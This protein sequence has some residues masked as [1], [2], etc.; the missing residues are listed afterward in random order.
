MPN[1]TDDALRTFLAEVEDADNSPVKTMIAYLSDD[2][3]EARARIA[4]LEG[5]IAPIKRFVGARKE[6]DAYLSYET[7]SHHWI[8]TIT[9]RP[10]V[11]EIVK[12][13]WGEL[14]VAAAT[15]EG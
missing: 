11:D 6:Q 13:T 5:V 3:F 10:E 14:E 8:K 2:I 12:L 1:Y 7:P 15:L 9:E 4:E